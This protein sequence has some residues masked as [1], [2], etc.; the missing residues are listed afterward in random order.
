MRENTD[1]KNSKYFSR[2]VC[3]TM[4]FKKIKKYTLRNQND[5]DIWKIKVLFIKTRF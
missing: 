3:A 1:Q 5:Q 2:S 4:Y